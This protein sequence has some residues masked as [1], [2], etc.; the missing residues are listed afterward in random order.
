M[1]FGF[2]NAE[3][4]LS[5]FRRMHLILQFPHGLLG[6]TGSLRTRLTLYIQHTH[7]P[8]KTIQTLGKCCYIVLN[9]KC[10][11]FDHILIFFTPNSHA[12][13]PF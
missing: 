5:G 2:T 13:S 7:T 12:Q 9:Y 8:S 3:L 11:I 1:V 4:C 6:P 10:K